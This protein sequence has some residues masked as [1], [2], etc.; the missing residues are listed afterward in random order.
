VEIDHLTIP[1]RDYGVSKRFYEEALVPLGFGVR[2]D[3][4]DKRKVFFGPERSHSS[5]WLAESEAAGGLDVSL[6]AS[7]PEVVDAFHNAAVSAGARTEYEPGI[8]PEYNREYYAARVLDPDGNSLEAVYR[9]A[10][11]MRSPL[12]A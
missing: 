12:A 3:W 8:R 7:E 6:T 4:P 11:A 9:G 10:A 2:L 1:V 5:L